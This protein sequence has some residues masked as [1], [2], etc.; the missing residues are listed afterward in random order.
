MS[1]PWTDADRQTLADLRKAKTSMRNMSRILGRLMG[2]IRSE[3]ARQRE[4][5]KQPPDAPLHPCRHCGHAV[6]SL[7]PRGLCWTC[8]SSST[9]RASYLPLAGGY[10]DPEPTQEEVDA[11]VAEGM[12]CLPAWWNEDR[13]KPAHWTPPLVR[14]GRIR[15]KGRA[16]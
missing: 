4:T 8:F 13:P 11:M 7:R 12:L 9:I 6:V 15:F 1:R 10:E 14:V 3:L 5:A 2:D 16:E